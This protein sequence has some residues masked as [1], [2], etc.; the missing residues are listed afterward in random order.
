MQP[1]FA[2]A[3]PQ[4]IRGESPFQALFEFPVSACELRG[5]D[6]PRGLLP[7]EGDSIRGAV[8]ARV[9]EFAAGRHCAHQAMQ[10][11]GVAADLPL[12][13]GPHREPLWPPGLVGSITHTAGYCAAVV[14]PA[15]ACAGLG[16]D[17][18]Q[19]GQVGVELWPMLFD[20][21]EL[22][23]LRSMPP[24]AGQTMATVLF[25]AKEAFFKSHFRLSGAM[26][27][28]NHIGLHPVDPPGAF[29]RLT[30]ARVGDAR[31]AAWAPRTTLRYALHGTLVLASSVVHHA[32]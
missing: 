14:A 20:T 5:P 8:P 1:P 12:L 30:L 6:V 10:A 27:E 32:P 13:R 31:L 26:P 7:A 23:Q 28:F 17:A 4:P 22:A 21:E 19:C 16:I 9:A 2:A 25:S 15:A 18:E 29:G 11:F 24:L 3:P